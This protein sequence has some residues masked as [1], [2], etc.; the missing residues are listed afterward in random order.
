M[1]FLDSSN[2]DVTPEYMAG[3]VA[4][5]NGIEASPFEVHEV[6]FDDWSSAAIRQREINGRS[7]TWEKGN[8]DAKRD[9]AWSRR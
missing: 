8:R 9:S 2:D 3:Y 6:A 4:Y 7:Y 1:T 5:G